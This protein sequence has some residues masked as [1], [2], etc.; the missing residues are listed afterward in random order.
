MHVY[1]NSHNSV[2]VIIAN[3]AMWLVAI[4]LICSFGSVLSQELKLEVSTSCDN[5]SCKTLY[6]YLQDGGDTYFTSNTTFVFQPGHHE[7]NVSIAISDIDNLTLTSEGE[8]N[9][10][11]SN[12]AGLSFMNILYLK[13]E[14]LTFINCSRT[15]DI[16]ES[17][18]RYATTF[19]DI[20]TLVNM[21]LF[22]I[23]ITDL[24]VTSLRVFNSTGYGVFAIN[25]MGDSIINNS[26][27]AFNNFYNSQCSNCKGGNFILLYVDLKNCTKEPQ[28]HT[29]LIASSRF[30]HGV[31]RGAIFHPAR[32]NNEVGDIQYIGGS[33]LGIVETQSSYGVDITIQNTTIDQNA[34]Y[35]GANLYLSVF[36]FVYNSSI[37]INN[38]M[39][40]WGNY[41]GNI[42]YRQTFGGG[43]SYLYGQLPK[44]KNITLCSNVNMMPHSKTYLTIAN[45]NI[46]FNDARF[47]GAASI[48]LWPK[49]L[50]SYKRAIAMENVSVS[51]NNGRSIFFC[52]KSFIFNRYCS[53]LF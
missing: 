16:E 44:G 32:N 2:L 10:S 50:L 30:H 18:N 13:I 1:N 11:C 48:H 51:S 29:L 26:I 33:G 34:A 42:R 40:V 36:D 21:T 49:S 3:T 27:L 38:S 25:I 22:F 31:D 14:G 9:I 12:G 23:H 52:Y 6:D 15:V 4:L 41:V 7:L 43:F 35:I 20:N 28:Q 8:A 53:E 19:L 47:G 37:N 45:T 5:P 17:I 24:H 46:S 39:I